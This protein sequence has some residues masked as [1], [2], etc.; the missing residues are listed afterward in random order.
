[1][2]EVESYEYRSEDL[3]ANFFSLMCQHLPHKSTCNSSRHQILY[4]ETTEKL[5]NLGNEETASELKAKLDKLEK[6]KGELKK[7]E[8]ELKIKEKVGA[9][10]I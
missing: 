2:K 7:Q 4:E 1:M 3:I 9:C 8:E 10:S 6:E 5:K